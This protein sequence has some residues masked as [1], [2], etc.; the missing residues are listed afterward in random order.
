MK[1]FISWSGEKSKQVAVLLEDWI[2]MV[3]QASEPWVS[4]NIQSGSLWFQELNEQLKDVSI[5]IVCITAEN[6]D[7]PWILFETGALAKGLSTNRVC[8]LLIDL[9][10]EDIGQP[11]AQFNHTYPDREG[12]FKLITTINAQLDKTALPPHILARVFEKNW[13]EFESRIKEILEMQTS[14]ISKKTKRESD[15]ILKEVLQT[16]RSFDNKLQKVALLNNNSAIERE[17]DPV[18]KNE[19]LGIKDRDLKEDYLNKILH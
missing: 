18:Y 5:G 17:I 9:K 3:I 1:I 2:K 6:R 12:M 13:P 16:V 15:D 19:Q 8:T 11:L 4:T 7:K 14:F 10:N